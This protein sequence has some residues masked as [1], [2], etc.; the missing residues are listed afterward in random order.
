LPLVLDSGEVLSLSPS[1][2][3]DLITIKN[4]LTGLERLEK[5]WDVD[6]AWLENFKG[7]F[8][9]RSRAYQKDIQ[10]DPLFMGVYVTKG[11]P[12]RVGWVNNSYGLEIRI[13][14]KKTYV[15]AANTELSRFDEIMRA[16]MGSNIVK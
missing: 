2:D 16:H 9:Y 8:L 13:G 12:S 15:A 11:K 10:E 4:Y 3:S 5:V 1:S 14:E 7:T 6:N